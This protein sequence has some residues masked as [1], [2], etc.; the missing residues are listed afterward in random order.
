MLVFMQVQLQGYQQS[1]TVHMQ[2][3]KLHHTHVEAQDESQKM[4]ERKHNQFEV[5]CT[6]DADAIIRHILNR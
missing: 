4:R 2:G 6:F 3:T 5:C 1:T